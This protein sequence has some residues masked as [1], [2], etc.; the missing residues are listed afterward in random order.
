MIK[1][2]YGGNVVQNK[3]KEKSHIILSLDIGKSS[4]GFALVDKNDNYK[5]IN[6]GVRIF[7]APES[8]S[9]KRDNG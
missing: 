4:V 8:L 7:D 5:L 6:G 2:L 3:I 1:Y 9:K